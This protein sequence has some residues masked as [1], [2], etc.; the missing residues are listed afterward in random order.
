MVETKSIDW[1]GI[2]KKYGLIALIWLSII[3]GANLIFASIVAFTGSLDIFVLGW[4]LQVLVVG[5]AFAY[6]LFAT[7]WLWVAVMTNAILIT[8]VLSSYYWLNGNWANW[9]LWMLIAPVVLGTIIVTIILY[10]ANRPLASQV[11]YYTGLVLMVLTGTAIFGGMMFIVTQPEAIRNL[12]FAS[13]IDRA[14]QKGLSEGLKNVPNLP[15]IPALKNLLTPT[16]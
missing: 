16:P 6:V 4:P 8:G 1:W 11:A 3:V 5:F 15:D 7:R 2:I 10:V 12:P 13:V 14:V 9:T